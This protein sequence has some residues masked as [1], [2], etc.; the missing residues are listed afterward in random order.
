VKYK[1]LLIVLG[2]PYSTFSEIIFKFFRSNKKSKNPIL[3]IGSSKLLEKQM[4]KLNYDIEIKV[5]DRD[6][7]GK[8]YLSPKKI[9]VINVNFN[10]KKIFDKISDN[11]Y[12]YIKQCFDISLSL[13]KSRKCIALINGPISKKNFLK[14][15]YLGITEY[16]TKKTKTNKSAMLIYN[17]NFSVSPITTH[18]PVN[19][20]SKNITK[21]IIIKNVLLLNNFYRH[22]LNKK[23]KI[24]ILGLN[25]HC[26]TINDFSEEDKIIKPTV[27]ILAKKKLIIDGPYPADTFFNKRNIKK[28]NLVIGMYH[29]Q[30]LTPMK[31]IF[32]FDAINITLGLPFIRV[33]PD[34]GT[35]NAMIG[36]NKSN[37]DSFT[38]IINFFNKFHGH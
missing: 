27:K 32:G 11:S 25:P 21:K 33:S 22:Y 36:T 30:V 19:K 1:P 17:P 37:A 38:S 4:L 6:K 8:I 34:H 24:A 16:L 35:N 2:E 28:Y 10:F 31:T 26:E 5:I 14:K 18:L 23:A 20:I 15:K 7:V 3:F 9:N 13:L 29:D 12:N